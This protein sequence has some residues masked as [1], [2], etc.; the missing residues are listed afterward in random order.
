MVRPGNIQKFH[1]DQVAREDGD[2]AAFRHEE[3]HGKEHGQHAR[4]TR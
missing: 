2:G 3:G 1:A 4:T